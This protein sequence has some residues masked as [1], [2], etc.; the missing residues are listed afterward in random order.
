MSPEPRPIEATTFPRTSSTQLEINIGSHTL[1]FEG[2]TATGII[3][4]F[5][6]TLAIIIIGLSRL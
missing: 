5:L 2:W 4:A 6:L 1:H 3:I